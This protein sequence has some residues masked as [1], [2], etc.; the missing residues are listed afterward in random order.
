MKV[1]PEYKSFGELFQQNNVFVTPKY[2]R[3]YSWED[4]QIDQ[5]CEDIRSALEAE[6]EKNEHF[7]GGIVCAQNAGVGN[8]KIDNLLV[9]GQQRLSTIILFFSVI[10][11]L[12]K[13]FGCNDDDATYR[14]EL[15]VQIQKYLVF[16]ERVNRE[17]NVYSRIKIGASD[18]DF[19]Q[20]ALKDIKLQEKRSSHKLIWNAKSKFEFFL[21]KDLLKGLTINQSLDLIDRLISLFEGKFLLIHI[22]ATTVDD[23]YKLF[24]V[25]NDRGINLTEGELLKAHSISSNDDTVPYVTQIAEKW[26]EI[27][28]H[29]TKDVSDFLRWTIIM[30]TGE[31]ISNSRIIDKFKTH[32]IT[33]EL[34]L[35]ETASRV[36]FIADACSR[37][38]L[39]LSAEWPF[40]NSQ[41]TTQFHKIKLDWLIKKMK[42]THSMPILLAATYSSEMEFQKLLS[43]LCK[44]FIRY[45][46]ISNLHA[47]IF[48]DLYPKLSNN[49]FNLKDRFK[50]SIV[51]DEFRTIL[52]KK[53]PKNE[54]F[55]NG[56]KALSYARKGDNR[57]IKYLLVT[58]QENWTWLKA[59]PE[60]P[61][62]NRLILEEKTKVFD[63]NNTT[64][65]HL[66]PYSAKPDDVNMD[67]EPIK[68][69][70]GNL[71]LLDINNNAKNDNKAFIDKKVSFQNTGIGAHDMISK[72]QVWSKIEFEKLED[73]YLTAS[74]RVFSF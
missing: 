52:Q 59:Q 53:D 2:Q 15:I 49:I 19:Y 13:S 25:L 31:N 58:L 48:S 33:S 41:N 70:L 71:A 1:T 21:D 6:D 9:D 42:H 30:L 62:K 28:A 40:E 67:M 36:D 16:E 61:V 65:E 29:D 37:L 5:F 23:A 3:D 24:M 64:I 66:Y 55:T 7:F 4:E 12:L 8:R 56:I 14:D 10:E 18:N 17:K 43:E 74:L 26:D 34:D 68:N 38:K 22:I 73:E 63:F 50:V 54:I 39:L 35:K 32:F 45:K 51:Q 72:E 27:L 47:T 69:R 57:P 60:R 44:F 11:K 46:I 20:S